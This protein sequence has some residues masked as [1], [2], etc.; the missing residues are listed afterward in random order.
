M[1]IYIIYALH[2][3]LMS[4]WHGDTTGYLSLLVQY[5]TDIHILIHTTIMLAA[6]YHKRQIGIHV[7]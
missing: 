1:Y 6:F 4:I 2:M 3:T 5:D 7:S